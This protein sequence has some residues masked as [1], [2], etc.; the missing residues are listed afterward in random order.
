MAVGVLKE[1]F[2]GQAALCYEI[3]A[4]MSC[5]GAAA[6]LRLADSYASLAIADR[7]PPNPLVPA[8]TVPFCNKCGRMT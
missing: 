7:L 1:R 5:E 6:I 4:T 8:T 3:A 2:R